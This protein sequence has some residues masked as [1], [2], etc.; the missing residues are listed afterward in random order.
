MLQVL[1]KDFFFGNEIKINMKFWKENIYFVLVEPREPGNI[2][3]SAR[4]IK[5]M[6]FKNLCLVNPQSEI[7]DEARLLAYNALDVLES[8]KS[9]NKLTDALRD[10]SIVVGTTR[11]SGKSRGLILPV[12]EGVKRVFDIARDNKVA[13]LFGREDKGLFNVEV[14]E[15]GFLI[16]IPTSEEQPSLNLS[17]AV[18]I[19]AYELSK[20][21]EG[22][23]KADGRGRKEDSRRQ[24]AEYNYRSLVK[25]QELNL[26]YERISKSLDLLG[27]TPRGDDNLKIKIMRNLKHFIG[28]SG[29]TGWELNMLHGICSQIEK[30]L[31]K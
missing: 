19:I 2:G 22:G 27:Y 1:P 28:R 8:A 7:G 18:L 26:L 4:A 17:Q 6:G 5:N 20:A 9:Y 31:D 3:A 11:R 29:I 21:G 16:T 30:K 12:E 14:E 23:Q 15:C 10:K 24:R 13:I 25:Q